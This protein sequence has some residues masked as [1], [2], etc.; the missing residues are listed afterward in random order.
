MLASDAPQCSTHGRYLFFF[1]RSRE[2]S[3]VFFLWEWDAEAFIWGKAGCGAGLSPS[4]ISN[5]SRRGYTK[6]QS[7]P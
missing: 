3:L 1:L 4:L 6:G 7:F 5:P 2:N